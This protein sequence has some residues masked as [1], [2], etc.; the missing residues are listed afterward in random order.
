MQRILRAGPY[1]YDIT[2]DRVDN[3]PPVIHEIH[4]LSELIIYKN[5]N[6]I[7]YESSDRIKVSDAAIFTVQKHGEIS[8]LNLLE[9][10]LRHPKSD[11]M[12]QSVT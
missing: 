2:Y 9:E 10:L 6:S 1:Y 5:G 8:L 7:L 4:A 11:P 12:L 3:E